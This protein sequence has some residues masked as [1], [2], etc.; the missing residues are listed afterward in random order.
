[1]KRGTFQIVSEPHPSPRRD[2]P[3]AANWA[4]LVPVLL[5]AALCCAGCALVFVLLRG[6]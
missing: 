6:A 1:M 5:G 3:V 4:A 2:K